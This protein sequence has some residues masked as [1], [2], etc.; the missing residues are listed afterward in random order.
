MKLH[1]LRIENF[2]RI[3]SLVLEPRA[4]LT[5]ISGANAQ[6][7]TSILEAISYLSTGRSFRTSRDRECLPLD[8]E[9]AI[10][11]RAEAGFTRADVRHTLA[12]AIERNRKTVWLD[13]K[14]VRTLSQ[15]LGSLCTVVFTP[16]DIELPRGA[17]A[18]RRAFLDLLVAQTSPGAVVAL[19]EYDRA[20]RE[21]NALLRSRNRA[22]PGEF[23]AFESLMATHGAAIMDAR[24]VAAAD[25]VLAASH[26]MDRLGQGGE[27]I[28][29]SYE[30]SAP[31]DDAEP[32]GSLRR[33]WKEQRHGDIEAGTTRSGPHRDD[34]AIALAGKDARR[35]ASQGQ[36]RSIALVLRLA[37]ARLLADR[38]G[39]P[40]LLLL[41][42]VLGE[43][44][45]GRT[46]RFLAEIT[47]AGMQ[48][49][50]AV[51]DSAAI[52]AAGCT[53]ELALTL[54]AGRLAPLAGNPQ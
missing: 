46:R 11:A 9:E 18:L 38:L 32:E 25:L 24:R 45:E 14:P 10:C 44:D 1:Q 2:R 4:G 29:I 13:D 7:K 37:E 8:S 54:D 39:E 47:G 30:V 3:G 15:L 50:L 28:S 17:P 12:I 34:I 49:I 21:R 6:G 52:V 26:P 20:L 19:T 36:C 27:T 40:P 48:A 23:E 22:T 16:D 51:T 41:D 42:D 33:I 5:L 35:Y 43:L 31:I 53:P